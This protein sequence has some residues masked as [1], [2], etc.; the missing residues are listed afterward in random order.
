MIS[1][2]DRKTFDIT[3]MQT[4]L[5]A[6][7]SAPLLQDFA[8]CIQSLPHLVDNANGRPELLLWRQTGLS[9]QYAPFHHVNMG[10]K[11]MLVGITAGKTQMNRALNAARLAL[12]RGSPVENAVSE[13]KKQSSFSGKMRRPLIAMLDKLGHNKQLGIVSCASLWGND[14]D[15]VHFCSL[16]KHPVFLADGENYNGHPAPLSH[17]KLRE[18]L[19]AHFVEDLKVL[20]RD[21]V[22]LPLGATVLAT[23]VSLK[24][25]GLV[26]QEIPRLGD[27]HV[28][29]PHPSGENSESILL[30]LEDAY[31]SEPAYCERMY[32]DYLAKHP[33]T[34]K[35]GRQP[36]VELKY[37]AS[38]SARWRAVRALRQ[39]YRLPV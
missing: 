3:N 24:R 37:K 6:R 27:L 14:Y 26:S 32:R 1:S 11:L 25:Q 13:V 21:A 5:V 15:K 35:P 28:A 31:P 4:Q 19:M 9:C 18:M 23:L 38:R 20:P 30:L 7:R 8:V 17:A 10:A 16:L 22:L 39:A 2:T 34:K 36:Q 29:L 33:W 12:Q